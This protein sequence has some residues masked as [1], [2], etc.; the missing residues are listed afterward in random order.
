MTGRTLDEDVENGVV[1]SM[2]EGVFS[3]RYARLDL[4]DDEGRVLRTGPLHRRP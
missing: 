1:L 4:L 3:L 2:Y